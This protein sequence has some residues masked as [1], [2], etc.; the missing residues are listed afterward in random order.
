MITR[1]ELVIIGCFNKTHGVNGEISATFDCEIDSIPKFK[2]IVAQID[3]IFVPFI[4]TSFRSN[5]AGSSLISL[6]NIS[7]NSEAE[8]L[9]NK[10]IYAFKTEYDQLLSIN[11]DNDLPIDYFINFTVIDKNLGRLG[12]I[13]DI[14]DSTDN[15]LFMVEQDDG[16]KIFIPA[17]DDMIINI[18]NDNKTIKMLL[19]EGILSL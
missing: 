15:V 13:I 12:K 3:G 5:I 10:S 18:N 9:S 19:P 6:E 11:D 7:N 17:V 14:D 1:D 2:F 4:I 16:H 8:V